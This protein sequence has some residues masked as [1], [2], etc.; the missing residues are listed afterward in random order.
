[1]RRGG[2]CLMMGMCKAMGSSVGECAAQE[3][4]CAYQSGG[5]LGGGNQRWCAHPGGLGWESRLQEVTA[6]STCQP[7]YG[8]QVHLRFQL[9]W[10]QQVNLEAQAGNRPQVCD[11]HGD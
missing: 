4:V 10:E 6:R 3:V 9:A 11:K 5:N 2:L 8:V 7:A 1:M